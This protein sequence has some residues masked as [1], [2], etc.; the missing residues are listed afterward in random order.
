MQRERYPGSFRA[1]IEHIGLLFKQD[2]QM[3]AGA[4]ALRE[5]DEEQGQQAEQAEQA[6]QVVQAEQAEPTTVK[7]EVG[8]DPSGDEWRE[9][10]EEEE[11]EQAGPAP[12]EQVP[13]V[14]P[15]K[16]EGGA[17]NESIA[18]PAP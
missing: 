10:E 17:A 4:G 9:Y 14:A 13:V 8:D 5:L 15:V 7:K 16:H 18:R 11:E 2:D 12:I 3:A 6:E 1:W